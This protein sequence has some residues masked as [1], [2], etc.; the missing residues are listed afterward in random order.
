[1]IFPNNTSIPSLLSVVAEK[2]KTCFL[3]SPAVFGGSYN[4]LN[5]CF[6]LLPENFHSM[7]LGRLNGL[8]TEVVGTQNPTCCKRIQFALFALTVGG[9]YP[10]I[11][12]CVFTRAQEPPCEAFITFYGFFCPEKQNL[13]IH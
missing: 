9:D 10:C 4:A 8:D 5:G 12:L 2:L 3:K 7:N 6:W 1:M 11:C 13:R